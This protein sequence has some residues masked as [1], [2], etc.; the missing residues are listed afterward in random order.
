MADRRALDLDAVRLLSLW[1][2]ARRE[3]QAHLELFTAFG[4]SATEQIA[5]NLSLVERLEEE[6]HA[7]FLA[8]R[9]H[10]DRFQGKGSPYPQE[11]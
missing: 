11:P 4:P 5:R 7:R 9:N 6:A 8:F 10:L 2:Q 3:L 1:F